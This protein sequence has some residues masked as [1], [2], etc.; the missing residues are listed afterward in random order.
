MI[1]EQKNVTRISRSDVHFSI[2]VGT[3]VP[4][5]VHLVVLPPTIVEIVPEYRGYYYVVVED[6]LLIIDPDT[7]EIVAVIR[8]A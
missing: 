5:S 8:L 6:D 4:S 7:H 2:S 1:K 3:R